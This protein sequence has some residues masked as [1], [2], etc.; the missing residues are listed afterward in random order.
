M[1]SHPLK[2]TNVWNEKISIISVPGLHGCGNKFESRGGGLK[3]V[4][5][6]WSWGAAPEAN[7]KVFS[8]QH[9]NTSHNDTFYLLVI[10]R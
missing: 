5:D 7:Y 10:F 2:P 1:I 9:Y 8:L 4:I 3:H 6:L